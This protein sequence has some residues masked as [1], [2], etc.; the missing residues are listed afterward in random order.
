M[1]PPPQTARLA[2]RRMDL[3][4]LDDMADLL[5]DPRVMRHYPR[6]KDRAEARG[7]VE[8]NQRL[9]HQRG[10]GL[11]LLILR[12][13]GAFVGD[14]GLTPQ[15]VDGQVD[16]ELGYHVRAELW[17]KGYATEAATACRD[18]ARDVLGVTRL[19][20]IIDPANLA[21]QR[22]ASKVG[23]I[24][25]QRIDRHGRPQLIFAMDPHDSSGDTDT[26]RTTR[27]PRG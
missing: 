12:D 8:W 1:T 6:P 22:V 25:E 4:D 2:L 13:S 3:G 18:W 16:I 9:Y 26:R 5:G 7:W 10:H 15:T 11:W 27:S 17:G 23:L 19:I 21:S 20:A 24:E 14:C